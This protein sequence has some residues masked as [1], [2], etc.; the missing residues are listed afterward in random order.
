[1]RYISKIWTQL[2]KPE[3]IW[4]IIILLLGTAFRFF[5][6][7]FGLPRL[8]LEDEEFFVTPALRVAGGQINPDWFGTPAQPLIYA[9]G[10]TFRIIS[11]IL[12]WTHGTAFASWQNYAAYTTI[13]QTAGRVFP[14]L[15]GA[16]SILVIY[17]VPRHWNTR[18]GLIAAALLAFSFYH[19]D[20]SHIIRPD[21]A[22][23]F[24]ILLM[25]YFFLRMFDDHRNWWWYIL[26]GASLGLAFNM[27]YP[28]MF[29][30][31][32]AVMVMFLLWREEKF[33]WR[34]WVAWAASGFA[35]SFITGPFLY[36]DFQK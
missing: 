3:H 25:L 33:V 15:V 1:M 28:S 23:M 27:K 6:I 26:S 14:I 19:V 9:L 35:A 29:F 8:Y 16:L 7:H 30:L 5:Y 36:L 10:I 24:F 21:V 2:K 13:F 18:S 32:P 22:Q 31:A 34:R 11:I 20:Q 4:L 17:F 12:N